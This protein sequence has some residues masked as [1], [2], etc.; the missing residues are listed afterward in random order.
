MNT[1]IQQRPALLR[2]ATVTAAVCMALGLAACGRDDDRTVGQQMD[3]TVNQTEQTAQNAADATREAAQDTQ[4]AARD[5][6]QDAGART[7]AM[8][9]EAR[10]DTQAVAQNA[11]AAVEDAG[12][13]ARVNAELAKDPNLSAIRI[14]VDTQ[15][16]VVTLT[17]PV[18]NEQ[19][20]ERATQI[21]HNVEGVSR[22]V[23]NLNMTSGS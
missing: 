4:T 23:N 9:D 22:V 20:R 13:T 7:E 12:I 5:A 1:T 16:G 21:A 19:A 3:T 6:A 11:Q 18:D 2:T 17:G 8:G 14:D 10:V 15:D